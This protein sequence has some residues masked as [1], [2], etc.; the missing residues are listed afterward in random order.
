ML[1]RREF[2]AK[3]AT[4][5]AALGVAAASPFH[6]LAPR[7]PAAS[8]SPRRPVVSIHMDQPYLDLTGRALP[9]IPPPGLRGAAPVAHLSE[10]EFRCRFVYL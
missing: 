8:P 7:S 2:V 1:T 6:A 3:I 10:L 4:S 5:A 9:Y